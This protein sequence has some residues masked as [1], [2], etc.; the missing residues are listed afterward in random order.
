MLSYLSLDAARI[1]A[2][3][4]EGSSVP[5]GADDLFLLY[6]VLMRAKGANVKA[7]DVHDAWAAWMLGVDPTHESIVPYA[8]LD[9]ATRAEDRPFLLAIRRAAS[10]EMSA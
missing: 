8:E 3:L 6:A 7:E 2:A 10:T 1:R 9:P 5:D 4:P